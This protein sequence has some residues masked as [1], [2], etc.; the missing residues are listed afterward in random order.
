MSA[1]NFTNTF[2]QSSTITTAYFF[3]RVQPETETFSPQGN[4]NT[5]PTPPIGTVQLVPFTVSKAA[6]SPGFRP[7]VC[8]GYFDTTAPAGYE[9]NSPLRIPLL[10]P[11][12]AAS[13]VLGINTS[14]LNS[15]QGH[16]FF[17]TGVTLED[18]N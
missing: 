9:L 3:G 12:V 1:G 4:T 11:N 8:H 7:A 15:Y 5:P 16:P 14:N 13:C 18:L 17:I 2:C 10:R 6:N